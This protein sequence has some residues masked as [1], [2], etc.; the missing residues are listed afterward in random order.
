[1]TD[2]SSF[3]RQVR[4][5]GDPCTFRE[6]GELQAEMGKLTHPA[7]PDVDW[8]RVESLC[9]ALFRQNGVELQT[10]VCYIVARTKQQ[11]LV[12]MT[13]GLEA[14]QTLI[15]RHWADFWP[16]Q[17]HSRVTLLSWLAEKIQQSLRT[18]ETQYHDLARVY[19]CEQYLAEL[20]KVLRQC[21]LWHLT[22]MDIVVGTLRNV[23]LRLERLTPQGT[24]INVTP[25]N[26]LT[27]TPIAPENVVQLAV[28]P[29]RQAAATA[30]RRSWPVFF[31]GMMTAA[32]LSGIGIGGWIFLNQPD[33]REQERSAMPIS[34]LSHYAQAQK[35]LQRLSQQ[36]DTLDERKG[37][38]LT[39]S[40]LKT[41][42]FAIRQSLQTPPLEELL[43]QL[44]EQTRAGEV[45]PALIVQIETRF[46]QLL[47]RYAILSN[48]RENHSGQKKQ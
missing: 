12:G 43:R 20:E 16:E 15:V 2:H 30:P 41:A 38:Y 3:L 23:A 39:A 33:L 37:K 31:A 29:E 7:R 4:A 34:E 9:L 48:S 11:G 18:M 35:Q 19:R 1:M 28:Q 25:I 26:A 17:A 6:S 27:T 21:E 47:N 40:E 45:T 14:L 10:L 13:D 24:D 46:Q 5:G 32:C 42:V 36:L 22:R 8:P 44:D